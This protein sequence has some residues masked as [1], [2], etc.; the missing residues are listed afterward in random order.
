M[1]RDDQRLNWIM[2]TFNLFAN[3][4]N[5]FSVRTSFRIEEEKQIFI[6]TDLLKNVIFVHLFSDCF[7]NEDEFN[8]H[9]EQS[10]K[11]SL[12]QNNQSVHSLKV[13]I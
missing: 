4:M 8:K 10:K 7:S 5:K 6:S 2:N 3:W 13:L 11:F 1:I 12:K 9:F